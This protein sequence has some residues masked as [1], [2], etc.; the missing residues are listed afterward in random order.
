MLK[1]LKRLWLLATCQHENLAS[2]FGMP[3]V[4]VCQDCGHVHIFIE[5]V[6]DY[7]E[8]VER[9]GVPLCSEPPGASPR[10]I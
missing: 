1:A 8:I 10:L 9:T 2:P 3:E 5:P 4:D 6:L 7:S